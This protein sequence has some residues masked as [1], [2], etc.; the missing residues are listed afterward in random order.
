MGEDE[1]E[2]K[3]KKMLGLVSKQ[4]ADLKK[5]C[6]KAKSA[7]WG[8]RELS[9]LTSIRDELEELLVGSDLTDV[10]KTLVGAAAAPKA[11][12]ILQGSQ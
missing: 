10:K 4:V 3:V 12:R 6:K 11:A 8:K 5:A 1:K 7:D 2:S 9:A